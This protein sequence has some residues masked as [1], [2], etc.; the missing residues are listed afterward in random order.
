MSLVRLPPFLF[1]TK[2]ARLKILDNDNFSLL[3][4]CRSFLSIFDIA[5]SNQQQ[6][7]QQSKEWTLANEAE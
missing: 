2:L 7:Q 6:Q 3:S 5:V 4:L 1:G